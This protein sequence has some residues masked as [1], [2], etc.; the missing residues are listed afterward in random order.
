MT[1]VRKDLGDKIIVDY[2]TNLIYHPYF[3]LLE[4]C[5]L[6]LLSKKPGRK[7][8]IVNIYD[9]QVERGCI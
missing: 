5:K 6:D 1:A 3:M 8:Q 2:R 9:N 7:M 4:I